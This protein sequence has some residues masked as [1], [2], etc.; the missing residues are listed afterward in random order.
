M[1]T[2]DQIIVLY[3]STERESTRD[4][5]CIIT[6]V[7][8]LF[9]DVTAQGFLETFYILFNCVR[10]TELLRRIKYEKRVKNTQ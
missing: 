8:Y 10:D 4:Y 9:N 2:F 1:N 6:S 5:P 7:S 3:T